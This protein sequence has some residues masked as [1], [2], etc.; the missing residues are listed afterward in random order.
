MEFTRITNITKNMSA[1]LDKSLDEII[2]AKSSA[3][4]NSFKNKKSGKFSKVSKA[5]DSKTS[6]PR[7]NVKKTSSTA[8]AFNATA[9]K[10]IDAS[11]ATKAVIY[12]LVC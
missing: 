4:K 8:A 12:G 11:S 7:P 5:R 2:A 3:R 10:V 9:N 6:K 1:S